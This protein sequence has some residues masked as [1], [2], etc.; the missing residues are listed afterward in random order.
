MAGTALTKKPLDKL[1]S[2]IKTELAAAESDYNNALAHAI[3]AGEYLS[4]AKDQCAHGT[5]LP[6]LAEHG[7]SRFTAAKYMRLAESN[8]PAQAHLQKA[9]IT[10]ALLS[11]VERSDEI[12]QEAVA[13]KKAIAAEKAAELKDAT[14]EENNL[15]KISKNADEDIADYTKLVAEA[16]ERKEKPEEKKFI[17]SKTKAEKEKAENEKAVKAAEERRKKLAAEAEKLEKE[18]ADAEE[19]A[20]KREEKAKERSAKGSTKAKTAPKKELSAVDVEKEREQ[21]RHPDTPAGKAA[22]GIEAALLLALDPS[23]T[24]E[25][26]DTALKTAAKLWVKHRTKLK[27]E[28]I[29]G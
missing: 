17:T 22:R 8:V 9:T 15:R 6:W 19:K 7:W 13:E 12:A 3:K 2:A 28:V 18:A 29:G 26:T 23:T 27:L 25:E 14:K 11:G 4:Q 5:W 16:K 10:S 20:T 1:A 21:L 24:D